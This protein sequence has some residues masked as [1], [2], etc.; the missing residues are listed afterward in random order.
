MR[1]LELG[2]GTALIQGGSPN[3]PNRI[4]PGTFGS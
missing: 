2:T 3:A 1:A 4:E